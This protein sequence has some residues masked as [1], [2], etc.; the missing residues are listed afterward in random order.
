M[1]P[2]ELLDKLSRNS[3]VAYALDL[4]AV[5]CSIC[6]GALGMFLIMRF[7]Q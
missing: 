1:K 3:S 6:L 7:R 4:V 2:D 5:L